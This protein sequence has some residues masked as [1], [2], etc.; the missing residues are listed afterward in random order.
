[1]NQS[2]KRMATMKS[3]QRGSKL[4][5]GGDVGTPSSI[6]SEKNKGPLG[7]GGISIPEGWAFPNGTSRP[8]DQC[9]LRDTPL[10][11]WNSASQK[12]RRFIW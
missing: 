7:K 3:I 6:V 2:L 9:R 8:Q 12:G 5:S 11:R 1:M 4:P 10:E